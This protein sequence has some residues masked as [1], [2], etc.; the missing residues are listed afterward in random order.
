MH[1]LELVLSINNNNPIA[2]SSLSAFQDRDALMKIE[3][4]ELIANEFNEFF[5]S[6]SIP[7]TLF[8]I[9]VVCFYTVIPIYCFVQTICISFLFVRQCLVEQLSK[10]K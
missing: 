2:A 6:S 8:T 4:A 10:I 7:T 9:H 1:G 3:S 5:L